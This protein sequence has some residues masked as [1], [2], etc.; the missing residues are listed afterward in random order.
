M[1]VETARLNPAWISKAGKKRRFLFSLR[2]VISHR[3]EILPFIAG[4]KTPNPAVS[5]VPRANV[6]L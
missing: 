2:P 1:K 6:A 5:R 4:K 3:R